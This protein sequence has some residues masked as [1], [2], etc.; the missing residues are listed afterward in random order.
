MAW[1]F[2]EVP[3]FL[4]IFAWLTHLFGDGIFWIKFWPSLFGALTYIIAGRIIL[5]L[6]GK[7]FALALCFLS[8]IYS[9]Y[10]RVHFLFQPNFPEIF[11]WTMIAWGAIRYVQT[12]KNGWLYVMGVSAGLGMM[13]KYS[14]LFFIVSVLAGILLTNQRKIFTNR[15]LYFAAAAG[16][17]IFL[18]NVIWQYH[19]HFP[20]FHHMQELKETQLQYI[21]PVSFI[22]DQFVM[23]LPVVF[24][25]IA[26]FIYAAFSPAGKTYRFVAL[27]YVFVIA[28]LLV[29]HGKSYY[30]LGVYPTL[31]AF[32]SYFLE[33]RTEVRLKFLRYVY[34]IVPLIFTW[35]FVPIALPVLPPQQLARLYE[36]TSAKKTGALHWE[37]LKD[38]PLPQDFADMLGWEEMA[39]K[40]A[41]AWNLLDSNEKKRAIIFCD[42]YG[43]A[44]AV[45]FYAKKYHIPAAYSDNASFLYWM[46]DSM[47]IENLVLLTDDQEEMQHPF[48]KDFVSAQLRDSVTSAYA[49][50]RGSLIILLK[51]ANDAFNQM[52]KEKIAKDRA[53]FVKP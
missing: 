1:G 15:H 52:F 44:G 49:R 23:F 26:G 38:H 22:I 24:V 40:A 16:F 53:V 39:Q 47:H 2:M 51:G 27:A 25:W 19:K 8:F 35:Q 17:I 5:S 43:Q 6:G 48:I 7:I 10:L 46:P 3:P 31:L 29:L 30:S 41:A 32:G 36:K 50:E 18:P 14:A 20:V 13:S 4:S 42:N 37:D 34:I 45:T 12:Q 9:G 11:F 21:S 28:I 33:K